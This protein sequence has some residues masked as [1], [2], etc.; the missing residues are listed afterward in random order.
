MEE[1]LG[2]PLV[3]TVP[4]QWKYCTFALFLSHSGLLEISALN[5]CLLPCSPI[6]ATAQ[7]TG[8]AKTRGSGP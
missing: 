1:G 4:V 3:S 8:K 5:I 7:F 2:K 6:Q